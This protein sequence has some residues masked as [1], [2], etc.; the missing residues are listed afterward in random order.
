MTLTGNTRV[1]NVSV[2]GTAGNALAGGGGYNA[3]IAEFGAANG[4]GETR[5]Q[6]SLT[7][8]DSAVFGQADNINSSANIVNITNGSNARCFGD[9]PDRCS[10]PG[11]PFDP[12]PSTCP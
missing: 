11:S 2:I 4:G 10:N 1:D 3:V 6:G 5:I 8:G 12:P 9:C 7:I